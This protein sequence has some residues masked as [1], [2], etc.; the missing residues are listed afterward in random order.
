MPVPSSQAPARLGLR[1]ARLARGLSLEQ[2]AA[3]AR[4][5]PGHL[6]RIERGINSPTAAVL[7]RLAVVYG[8][9]ELARQLARFGRESA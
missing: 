4:V 3:A 6:S 8:L 2:V 1:A 5:D 9:D 7:A